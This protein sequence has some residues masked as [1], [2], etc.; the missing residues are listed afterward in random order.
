[1]N[2]IIERHIP[3]SY[4]FCSNLLLKDM[5]TLATEEHFN[6][7]E[8][9]GL[10]DSARTSTEFAEELRMKDWGFFSRF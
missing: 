6:N 4:P 10:G 8:N 2:V 3:N 7:S 5:R 9:D 1:M